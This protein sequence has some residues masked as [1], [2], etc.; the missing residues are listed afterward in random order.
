MIVI[1]PQCVEREARKV[2]AMRA[3]SAY[4]RTNQILL[5]GL[6]LLIVS[7]EISISF[8]LLVQLVQLPYG[9]FFCKSPTNEQLAQ[10]PVCND[11]H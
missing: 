11:I 10:D 6:T 4:G 5:R 9:T 8:L 2:G 1:A 7:A 3:Y